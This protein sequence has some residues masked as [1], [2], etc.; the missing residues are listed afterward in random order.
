MS[1]YMN[2]VASSRFELLKWQER[3]DSIRYVFVFHK[4]ILS[5]LNHW[6]ASRMYCSLNSFPRIPSAFNPASE[7]HSDLRA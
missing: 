5:R 6:L 1:H 3:V 2:H 4:R 7:V